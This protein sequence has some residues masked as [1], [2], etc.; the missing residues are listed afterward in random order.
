MVHIVF[1]GCNQGMEQPNIGDIFVKQSGFA[2]WAESNA[3]IILFPQIA[4][5]ALNPNGCWDWWGYTGRHFLEREAPQ[6]LAVKA[7]LDRLA[8]SP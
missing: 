2:G 6:M 4:I 5:S 3:I 7:M 8:E 1:H